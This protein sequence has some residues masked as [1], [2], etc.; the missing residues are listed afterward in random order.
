[1]STATWQQRW[2]QVML[3]NYGTPALA[4]MSGQGMRVTDADGKEYLDFLAGIAV[5]TLGHAHPAIADAISKQ[6]RD[7]MHVSNLAIHPKLSSNALRSDSQSLNFAKKP[8]L[9]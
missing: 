3:N 2:Q 6:A 9:D 1:M 7:L 4:L 8:I 5:N